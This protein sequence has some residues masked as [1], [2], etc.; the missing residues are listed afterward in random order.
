MGLDHFQ[1][2]LTYQ[3]P[4]AAGFVTPGS[5]GWKQAFGEREPDPS[6]ATMQCTVDASIP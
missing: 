1:I 4:R 6:H 5:G 3:N 2:T